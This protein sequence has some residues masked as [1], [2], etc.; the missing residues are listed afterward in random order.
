MGT[1][2]KTKILRQCLSFCV[3]FSLIYFLWAHE[4][5]PP[6]CNLTCWFWPV[7]CVVSDHCCWYLKRTRLLFSRLFFLRFIHTYANIQSAAVLSGS[8]FWSHSQSSSYSFLIKIHLWRMD[9]ICRRKNFHT[10]IWNRLI[11]CW[12]FWTFDQNPCIT[13]WSLKPSCF[14][15]QLFRIKV[16]RRE[17]NCNTITVLL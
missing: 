4:W 9:D 1:S 17:L 14:V 12:A 8:A 10:S 5:L 6:C 2:W 15:F 11:F 3:F 16:F 13:T 7:C